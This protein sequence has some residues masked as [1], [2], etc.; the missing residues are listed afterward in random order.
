[1]RGTITRLGVVAPSHRNVKQLPLPSQV[2]AHTHNRAY[3]YAHEHSTV[4][5]QPRSRTLRFT[6]PAALPQGQWECGVIQLN[7]RRRQVGGV[8]CHLLLHF[9]HIG[10]VVVHPPIPF[11]AHT[12]TYIYVSHADIHT[13]IHPYISIY[14]TQAYTHPYTRTHTHTY[15]YICTP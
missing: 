6:K 3:C 15:I 8:A 13:H 14:H 4:S 10:A 12:H 1:M 9:T 7:H 2:P 11:Q 5:T